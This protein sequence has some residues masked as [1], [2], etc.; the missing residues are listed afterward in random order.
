MWVVY[1]VTHLL[2]N[3]YT[4]LYW[5]I[6][7]RPSFLVNCK[8]SPFNAWRNYLNRS[9][10]QVCQVGQ[11]YEDIQRVKTYSSGLLFVLVVYILCRASTLH[12]SNFNGDSVT[13]LFKIARSDSRKKISFRTDQS[14]IWLGVVGL[15]KSIKPF[16]FSSLTSFESSHL[17]IQ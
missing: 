12:F 9:W 16:K 17:I 2:W 13:P 15:K 7:H 5:F 14:F 1:T 10:A 6:H 3:N 4:K 8:V 11:R